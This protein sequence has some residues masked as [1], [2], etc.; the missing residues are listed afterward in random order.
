MA[1]AQATTTPVLER[2]A[3]AAAQPRSPSA[4]VA[5]VKA[6]AARA[7]TAVRSAFKPGAH[8]KVCS[9]ASAFAIA[10]VVGR[11]GT[12]ANAVGIWYAHCG[13]F[14]KARA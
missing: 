3:N 12:R 14:G 11:C 8:G 1:A 9:S 13:E 6:A 5:S 4:A 7:G 2:K 10:Q